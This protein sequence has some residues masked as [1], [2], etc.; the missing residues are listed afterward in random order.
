MS[1]NLTLRLP[2]E[3]VRRALNAQGVWSEDLHPGAYGGLEV[4]NPFAW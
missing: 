1:R 2:P 3:L 4:R